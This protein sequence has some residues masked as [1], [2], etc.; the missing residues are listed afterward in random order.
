MCAKS[1]EVRHKEQG[2]LTSD[3]NRR[4]SRG[5]IVTL[6]LLALT[7]P[8]QASEWAL[9]AW[10]AELDVKLVAVAFQ[11]EDMRARR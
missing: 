4:R 6:V 11:A 1:V 2:I 7:L 8:A 3:L 10:L 9:E 5:L